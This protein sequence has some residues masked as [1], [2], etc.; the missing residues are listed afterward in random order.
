MSKLAFLLN[1]K[2]EDFEKPY[3]SIGREE[4]TAVLEVLKS[5][6]LSGF[7]GR[8]GDRFL[9]GKY[10]RSFEAD[11]AKYFSVK[12]VISFNSAT[13]ALQAAITAA[14]IGPGDE[15]ITSPFTM[16]ASASAI[17]FNNALPVFADIDDRTFCL[18]VK[19]IEKNISKKT[20]AIM[21]I[22]LF[23]GCPNYDY[24]LKIAREHNLLVIEDNA[25]GA[26]AKYKNKFLGTIGDMGIFSFNVHKTIQ[27]GEGGVLV[28]NNKKFAFRA[29]L[30]RNHGEVVI[31]DLENEG[32]YEPILGGNFRFSEIN[33]A[34]ASEQLKKLKGL[35]STRIENA[36]YLTRRLENIKW[37]IPFHPNRG[38]IC[39]YYVYPIRFL[40]QKIGIGRNT[41]AKA[42]EAE[43]F[44]VSQGYQK[45]L[46]LFPLYQKTRIYPDSLFPFVSSEF[47]TAVSY[48]KGIC[49][50][51]ERL[52]DKEILTTTIF[53]PPND[54]KVIDDF[55]SKIKLIENNIDDLKNY[56]KTY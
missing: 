44:P 26:G 36:Q 11:F 27:S 25:Q 8:A 17:L 18:D 23:G 46:Y 10:V 14:G 30:F 7:L 19:S 21:V 6:N 41:F 50:V 12:Y 55:V 47:R 34:I 20:R 54:S 1:K 40:S 37:L 43:G 33:A 39:T 3:I 16:S 15:V 32:V 24:I 49:P 13:S 56:E 45:P 9:G 53:Q 28:T 4:E 2:I 22:N 38:C 29:Q 35:N 42:M 51:T 48:K 31:D 52:F 5:R